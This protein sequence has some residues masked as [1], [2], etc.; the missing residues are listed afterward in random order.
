MTG[1]VRICS[2]AVMLIVGL[3]VRVWAHPMTYLGTVLAV[4]ATRVQVKAVDEMTKKE[5]TLWF[6]IDEHTIVK[7]GDTVV[8]AAAAKIMKG[9][10]IA[11]I[12]DMDAPNKLH[13]VEIRLADMP[14]AMAVM[15]GSPPATGPAGMPANMPGMAGMPAHPAAPAGGSAAAH[16]HD[17]SQQPMSHTNMDNRSSGWQFAQDGVAT[18]LFNHQGGPRGGNEFV[19]PNWWMGMAM[20]ESGAN[21]FSLDAMLSLDPATVGKSGYRE[22]FQVGETLDGKA[23]VDRQHPHDLFMQLAASWRRTI[24]DST[25]FV[26]AGGPAGEPTLGPVAFMHRASAAGLPMAP[27][28]HHTF[29]STH[30]SFGVASAA[31]ERGR[32]TLEGSVFNGREPDENR[33]DLDFGAMDS[34]AARLWFRPT[35]EWAIQISTGHLKEPEA[36]EP[37]DVQRTTGSASWF[38]KDDRGFKAVTAGYGVNAVDGERRQGAFGEFT[39]ERD[40]TSVF[41]RAELQDV[42]AGLLFT[43]GAPASHAFNP[44]TT[45]VTAVTVGAARRLLMWRGFEGAIGTQLTAYRVPEV[46]RTTHGE[47]PV[48]FQMFFRM[49]LPAGSMGR[50]WNMRMSEGHKMEMGQPGHVMR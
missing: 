19:V 13:A 30:I 11:V 46:L 24:N 12:V 27:L 42:E 49:R 25:A 45:T 50:M 26:I 43:S 14:T 32:W 29:D 2:V 39:V 16:Q 10:R 21:H 15:R 20:R 34:V 41:G 47:H 35:T 31:I 40:A 36:L 28:G 7:R 37:G 8:S 48:S 17:A 6:V 44:P 33:W 22:I 4:E 23:L 5:T 18:G 38:R 9:E 3:G 1:V